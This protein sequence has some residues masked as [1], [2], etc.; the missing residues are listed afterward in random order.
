[1]RTIT[2]SALLVF[3]CMVATAAAQARV[4][5]VPSVSFWST[6]DSNLF[7]T[8]NASSDQMFLVT[9][10]LEGFYQSPSASLQGLYSFDAQRAFGHP[11][12]NMLDARRHAIVESGLG[13]TRQFNL[14]FN[15]RYDLSQ[16]PNELNFETGV[17]LGRQRSVRWQLT[18]GLSY[19]VRPRFIVAAQYDYT[20]EGLARDTDGQMQVLRLGFERKQTPRWTWGAKYLARDFANGAGFIFAP[21]VPGALPLTVMPGSNFTISPLPPP[22]PIDA[23]F[24]R[25]QAIVGGVSWAVTPNMNLAVSAG[26]R[27][28]SYENSL[29]E[30]LGSY[31]QQTRLAAIGVEYWQG[32]TIVLGIRGPVQLQS[33]TAK[34]VWPFRRTIELGTHAGFFHIETL[35]QAAARVFHGEVVGSWTPGGPYIIAASY[36]V[37]F[38][39]GD[40]RSPLLSQKQVV[41]QV[42]A[43]R[44]TVAPRL[45]GS[46][47]PKDPD[48]PKGASR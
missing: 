48:D 16:F 4:E 37:D 14:T 24:E 42:F 8:Q 30:V 34:V 39:K 36:G 25:S 21:P 47:R 28:A 9:P 13:V 31:T 29:P 3:T 17:L 45:R 15:G 33:S 26:P 23:S 27:I 35:K 32:E 44:M 12:L 43:V 46:I 20:S 41:R 7:A 6:Y 10:S 5:L 22:V 19:Q 38:Q 11:V 2:A 40:V 1:M 18:P